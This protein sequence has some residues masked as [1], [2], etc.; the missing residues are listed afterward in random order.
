MLLG[1]P[2]LHVKER[3]L[4]ASSTVVFLPLVLNRWARMRMTSLPFMADAA[5]WTLF[6][7][8]V[9]LIIC[10]DDGL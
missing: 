7:C 6:K 8:F 5:S 9:S 4:T 1:F 10:A 2:Y 3:N